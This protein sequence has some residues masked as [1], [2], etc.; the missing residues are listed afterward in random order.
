MVPAIPI[1]YHTASPKIKEPAMK[2]FWHPEELQD[3]EPVPDVTSILTV[4]AR[5]VAVLGALYIV[6]AWWMG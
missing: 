3:D 6:G 1:T 5:T 2:D 4:F